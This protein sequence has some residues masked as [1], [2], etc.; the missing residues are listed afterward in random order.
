MAKLQARKEEVKEE[1]KK[2]DHVYRF[3]DNTVVVR[4]VNSE[5]NPNLVGFVNI[6]YNDM[7]MADVAV[8][9]NKEGNPFLQFPSKPRIVNGEQEVNENG[10]KVYDSICGPATKAA[11]EAIL[12]MVVDAV[13]KDIEKADE[14][15]E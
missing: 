4:L 2:N 10:Y 8:K 9:T 5:K 13:N 14:K 7:F 11:Q 3:D 1:V 6:V 12:E 15:A